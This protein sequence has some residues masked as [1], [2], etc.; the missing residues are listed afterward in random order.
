LKLLMIHL[1]PSVLSA[2]RAVMA[3]GVS[4]VLMAILV[5]LMASRDQLEP[6]ASATAM[7]ML[8]PM[9]LATVID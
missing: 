2:L 8:I 5:I 7:E 6:V 1:A 9:P 4:N 3:L